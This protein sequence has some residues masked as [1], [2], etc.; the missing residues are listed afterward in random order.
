MFFSRHSVNIF[1]VVRREEL[2]EHIADDRRDV[3]AVTG[4]LADHAR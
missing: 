2:V 4:A 3:C 1:H